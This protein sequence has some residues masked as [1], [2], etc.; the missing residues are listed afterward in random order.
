MGNTSATVTFYVFLVALPLCL[1]I[2]EMQ[3][4]MPVPWMWG[5][6]SLAGKLLLKEREQRSLGD[7]YGL[8]FSFL[9]LKSDI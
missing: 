4:D 1:C 7:L 5:H 6:G 8:P 2:P 3:K 9:L